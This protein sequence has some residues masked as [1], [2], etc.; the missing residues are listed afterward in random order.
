M[1]QEMATR[2]GKCPSCLRVICNCRPHHHHSGTPGTGSNPQPAAADTA[3]EASAAAKIPSLNNHEKLDEQEPFITC[4][5]SDSS[6]LFQWSD[7]DG[8][9]DVLQRSFLGSSPSTSPPKTENSTQQKRQNISPTSPLLPAS[10][11]NTFYSESLLFEPEHC[12]GAEEEED[13]AEE[14]QDKASL[15]DFIDNIMASP[16][17]VNNFSQVTVDTPA[18]SPAPSSNVT[19]H[20]KEEEEEVE[21]SESPFLLHAAPTTSEAHCTT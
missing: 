18:E 6:Y 16:G 21:A 4:A 20:A 8:E 1:F 11:S 9:T 5:G 14:A 7:R 13:F 12:E 17:E 15:H 19:L 3:E 2:Q 10:P